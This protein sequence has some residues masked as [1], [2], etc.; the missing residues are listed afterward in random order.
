MAPIS[1]TSTSSL[2]YWFL[3]MVK[4]DKAD[5]TNSGKVVSKSTVGQMGGG[6]FN[7]EIPEDDKPVNKSFDWGTFAPAM[8]NTAAGIYQS[9]ASQK[10]ARKKAEAASKAADAQHAY[11]VMKWEDKMAL[12]KQMEA[13]LNAQMFIEAQLQKGATLQD[14]YEMY[15][16]ALQRAAENAR[17]GFGSMGAQASD[18]IMGSVAGFSRMGPRK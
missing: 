6:V 9:Y 7:S 8:I 14:A 5:S 1:E 11:D 16:N 2:P 3:Q 15:V 4:G 17:L 18:A 10:E 12:K 13:R